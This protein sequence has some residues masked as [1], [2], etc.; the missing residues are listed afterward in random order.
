MPNFFPALQHDQPNPAHM[1]RTRLIPRINPA[2]NR[3]SAVIVQI[4]MQ[5]AISR[6]EALLLQE[7]RIIQKRERIEDIEA[8]L[9]KLVNV[10]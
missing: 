5:R 1:L 10:P 7:Q 4:V 8:R 9:F 2:R 3:R 6:A